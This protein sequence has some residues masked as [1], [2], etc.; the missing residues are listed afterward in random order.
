M[1]NNPQQGWAMQLKRIIYILL[2]I[3]VGFFYY[4]MKGH[5]RRVRRGRAKELFPMQI[6]QVKN[7]VA[8]DAAEQFEIAERA[9]DKMQMYVQAGICAAAY[10]RTKDEAN[11]RKWLNIQREVRSE[12]GLDVR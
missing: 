5:F 10:L 9:G 8:E 1:M 4:G 6:Q 11:Y 7:T 2:V 3:V 12:L